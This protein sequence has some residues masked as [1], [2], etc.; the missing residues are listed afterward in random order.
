MRDARPD[1]NIET[2]KTPAL[3][4]ALIAVFRPGTR[5]VEWNPPPQ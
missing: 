5:V 4:T 3:Q 1:A 2:V